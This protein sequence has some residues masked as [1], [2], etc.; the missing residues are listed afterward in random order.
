MLGLLVPFLRVWG[1]T[2]LL[3]LLFLYAGHWLY[4]ISFGRRSDESPFYVMGVSFF[5]GL[6]FY[7]AL[8]RLLA[9]LFGGARAGCYAALGVLLAASLLGLRHPEARRPLEYLRRLSTSGLVLFLAYTFSTLAW[10]LLPVPLLNSGSHFGSI[11]SGRYAN[12]GIFILRHDAI[13]RLNQNYGQGLLAATHLFLG[14]P[15]PLASLTA[16]VA[17]A[18]AMLTLLLYGFFRQVLATRRHARVATFVVLFCNVALSFTHVVVFDN[19]SPLVMMGYADTVTAVATW[20][21]FV[22]W[23]GAWVKKDSDCS[24]RS[25]VCPGVLGFAW[26]VCAPQNV[27]MGLLLCGALAA[28][29]LVRHDLFARARSAGAGAALLLAVLA[30]LSQ[31]GMFMPATWAEETGLPGIMSVADGQPG[32]KI[33]PGLEFVVS[34]YGKMRMSSS[35]DAPDYARLR[36]EARDKGKAE[37]YRSLTFRVESRAWTALRMMFFP[38]AGIVGLRLVLL[39]RARPAG[40]LPPADLNYLNGS[41]ALC[42]AA[43]LGAA[44][45]FEYHGFKWELTRFLIPGVLLGL[46]SL[47]LFAH[48]V[49]RTVS[50]KGPRVLLWAVLVILGTTGPVVE[51]LV[52]AHKHFVGPESEHAPLS[53]RLETLFGN[54]DYLVQFIPIGSKK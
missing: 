6:S 43:G 33:R 1:S 45:V 50:S 17:L 39:A 28:F 19:G 48:A 27:V 20:L 4:R 36:S 22:V 53:A 30:G 21:V 18:L 16:W 3:A 54:R 35:L 52:T 37:V 34:H 10:W 23:L 26:N 2:F 8:F 38:I 51:F 15:S 42:L 44:F 11:H 13:P 29:A 46:I 47:I 49:E 24:Y 9:A 5:L 31:G 32:V 41:A 14:V 12:I 7:L 40:G 25:L